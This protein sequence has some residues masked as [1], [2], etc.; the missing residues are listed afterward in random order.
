MAS[1]QSDPQKIESNIQTIRNFSERII[2]AGLGFADLGE[3]RQAQVMLNYCTALL[4]ALAPDDPNLEIRLIEPYAERAAEAEGEVAQL[5][6]DAVDAAPPHEP[7]GSKSSQAREQVRLKAMARQW[8]ISGEHDGYLLN[9]PALT[10]VE[11]F[12]GKDSDITAFISASRQKVI[13]DRKFHRIYGAMVVTVLGIVGTGWWWGPLLSHQFFVLLTR[14]H[15][16]EIV[17]TE[18]CN[19]NRDRDHAVVEPKKVSALQQISTWELSGRFTGSTICDLVL[20]DQSLAFPL[21]FSGATLK[22]PF[23]QRV[24]GKQPNAPEKVD[25]SDS[26]I[27]DGRFIEAV[28]T[29]AKFKNCELV[30]TENPSKESLRY[31]SF[32]GASLERAD[33]RS[34]QIKGVS[35]ANADLRDADFTGANILGETDFTDANLAGA[36][37]ANATIEK[38]NF[39]DADLTH[40]DFRGSNLRLVNSHD[41]TWWLAIW[42]APLDR[43]NFDREDASKGNLYIKNLIERNGKVEQARTIARTYPPI[44]KEPARSTGLATALNDWAWHQAIYG[45]ELESAAQLALEAQSVAKADTRISDTIGYIYLQLGKFKEAKEAY[46]FIEERIAAGS[47]DSV[48]PSSRY[49]YGLVL[50]AL[51]MCAEA[52]KVVKQEPIYAAT[53]ERV[54]VLPLTPNRCPEVSKILNK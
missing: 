43:S 6:S 46:K 48:E 16:A 30:S 8:I 53:H 12:W 36:V 47:L 54:L 34:C 5:A 13:T 21:D 1:A 18:S 14:Q 23:L 25:F 29:D 4:F 33:F 2:E 51:G 17:E 32:E 41:T 11:A 37:F 19:E 40:T 31:T 7:L 45:L 28:L 39:N 22:R 27:E 44:L 24:K 38:P 9:G 3:R 26:E 52:E 20:T 50:A 49:R 35:F 15:A 42:N 10:K